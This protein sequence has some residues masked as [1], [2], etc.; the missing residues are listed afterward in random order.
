MWLVL[1]AGRRVGL[2]EGGGSRRRVMSSRLTAV[3]ESTVVGPGVGVGGVV[4]AC[5]CVLH[6][7]V[8]GGCGWKGDGDGRSRGGE[9]EGVVGDGR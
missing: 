8:V 7:G 2:V 3:F 9:G 6:C 1:H 4:V 5:S